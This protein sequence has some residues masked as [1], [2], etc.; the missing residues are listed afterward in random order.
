MNTQTQPQPGLITREVHLTRGSRCP[1]GY[2]Y[3]VEIADGS[4]VAIGT[5]LDSAIAWAKRE[6]FTPV[7]AW[8]K[9]A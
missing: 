8:K 1:I 5:R 4:K 9:E 2:L 6:G 7:K 3:S